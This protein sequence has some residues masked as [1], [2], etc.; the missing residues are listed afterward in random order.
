MLQ[1]ALIQ[2]I[3]YTLFLIPNKIIPGGL[4]GIAT[5]TYHLFSLPVGTAVLLMN[6]PLVVWGV[7][8][9]GPRFGIR[10]I[11]GI[12]L[13]SAFTDIIIYFF[14][15]PK[16]TDDLM[17][18]AIVGGVLVGY[19]VAQIFKT[20]ATTGG[21]E[22]VAQILNRRVQFSAGRSILAMNVVIIAAGVLAL[23]DVSMVIYSVISVYAISKVM[24]ASLEG[25]SFYKG[26]FVVSEKHDEIRE[27]V[28]GQIRRGVY[29][30]AEVN[31][32]EGQVLFTALTRREVAFLKEY[33]KSIDEKAVIVVFNAQEFSGNNMKRGVP[34]EEVQN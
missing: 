21:V 22:I 2:A 28:E 3:G 8:V 6:L 4:Y 12:V 30:L 32:G 27:Q 9:L 11:A 15:I 23:G 34:S 16:L 1:G 33:I 20:G 24:D 10:T 18:Q 5:V 29:S 14:G 25:V 17:V 7:R 19:G 31:E 13:T 26:I